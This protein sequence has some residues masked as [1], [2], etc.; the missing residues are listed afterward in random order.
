MFS[1]DNSQ[2][3]HKYIDSEYT[4]KTTNS[5]KPLTN[6]NI[7]PQKQTNNAYPNINTYTYK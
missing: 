4:T 3:L 2:T 5:R 6:L 1:T 7:V